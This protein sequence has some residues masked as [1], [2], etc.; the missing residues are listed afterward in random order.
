MYTHPN[1]PIIHGDLKGVGLDINE[2][3][4]TFC[5]DEFY[6]QHDRRPSGG[7]IALDGSGVGRGL[8]CSRPQLHRGN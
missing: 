4:W 3:L 8:G 2:R 7:L 5:P 6:I 1:G